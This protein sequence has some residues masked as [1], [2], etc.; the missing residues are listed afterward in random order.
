VE[1]AHSVPTSWSTLDSPILVLEIFCVQRLNLAL[2]TGMFS[3]LR[4][5]NL[6]SFPFWID[7]FLRENTGS[8]LLSCR[9]DVLRSLS[10]VLL[11]VSQNHD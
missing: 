8:V 3:P 1:K 10:M 6:S 4:K 5:L 2:R 9:F 11:D 7:F